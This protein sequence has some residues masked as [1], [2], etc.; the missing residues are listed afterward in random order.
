MSRPLS[1]IIPLLIWKKKLS[2]P[3]VFAYF[4]RTSP[5]TAGL[6]LWA[7]ETLITPR[8][9]L[10]SALASV[11]LSLASVG[12]VAKYALLPACLAWLVVS[13]RNMARA[14]PSNGLH[15]PLVKAEV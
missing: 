9:W 1:T 8:T 10:G 6:R 14:R 4:S 3:R 15:S 7:D 12:M 5:L 2:R 11:G 13:L